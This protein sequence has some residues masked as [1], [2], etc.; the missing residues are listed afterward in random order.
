FVIISVTFFLLFVLWYA[1]RQSIVSIP[2]RNRHFTWLASQLNLKTAGDDYFLQLEG[3]WNDVPVLIYPHNFE[4]PGL[5]TLFYADTRVA[6]YDDRSWIE[7]SIS[8]GRAIVEMKAGRKYQFEYS[9]STALKSYPI[10]EVLERYR[11]TYPYVA[12]TLPTRLVYSQYVMEALSDS[13]NYTALVV[14]DSGRRPSIQEMK[15][16]LDAV[17]DIAKTVQANLI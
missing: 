13:K 11:P 12:L 14:M 1:R 9:G 7:P 8:L 5:I 17:T 15:E 4:G 16:A 2:A 3:S 6:F 10:V